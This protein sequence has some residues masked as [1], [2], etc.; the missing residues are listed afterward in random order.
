[1]IIPE[2][3]LSFFSFVKLGFGFGV[4]KISVAKAR[5]YLKNYYWR[6]AASDA[7]GRFCVT[8]PYYLDETKT[9]YKDKPKRRRLPK[10]WK[11][12]Y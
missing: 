12:E 5:V 11:E 9:F 1:M 3:Y 6:K 2:T 4:I 8:Q 7:F 10:N